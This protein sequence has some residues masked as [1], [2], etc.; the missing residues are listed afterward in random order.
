MS[1]YGFGEETDPTGETAP[2]EQGPKWYREGLEKLS[3]QIAEIKAENDRLKAEQAKQAVKDTLT[4]QGY[5]PQVADLYTGKPEGL[6][7]WLSANGAL[8]VKNGEAAGEQGG[9]PTGPPATT[10][11]QESQAAQAAFSAAGSGAASGL[12][13]DDQLVARMNAAQTPEELD[14]IMREAGNRMV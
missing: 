5:A 10:V 7:D 13:G 3:G 6:N 1:N 12:S 11:S 2:T 4:A 9:A 14:A 8:F